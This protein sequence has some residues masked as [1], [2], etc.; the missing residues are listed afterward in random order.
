MDNIS[1]ERIWQEDS[2]FE[3]RARAKS[4][5]AWVTTDVYVTDAD[6]SELANALATF[7][8][9]S[10]S[11]INWQVS[12]MFAKTKKLSLKVFNKDKLG[13]LLVEVYMVIDDSGE[14]HNCCF[15]IQTEIGQL[16]TFGKNLLSVNKPVWGTK[17]SLVGDF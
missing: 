7:P 5:F 17:V 2:F 10:D 16:N 11:E 12:G 1:I 15:Y 8:E 4:Q 14:N 6:I 9:R 3:I 13:H